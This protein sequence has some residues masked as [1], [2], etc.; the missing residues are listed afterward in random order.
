MRLEEKSIIAVYDLWELEIM[1]SR[2]YQALEY[3]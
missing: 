1:S 2:P 3:E